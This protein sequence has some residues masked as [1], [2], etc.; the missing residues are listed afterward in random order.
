MANLHSGM[1]ASAKLKAAKLIG[2]TERKKHKR[3]VTKNLI[4]MNDYDSRA[5]DERP[6]KPKG[7]LE[8]P[9]DSNSEFSVP[10]S[11]KT[12]TFINSSVFGVMENNYE[13]YLYEIEE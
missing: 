3:E 4:G 6:F 12:D 11:Q 8:R 1:K 9:L 2:E 13:D 10:Q 5:G 7:T